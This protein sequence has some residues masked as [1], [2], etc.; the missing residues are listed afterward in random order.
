M[1][2]YLKIYLIFNNKIIYSFLFIITLCFVFINLINASIDKNGLNVRDDF[3][4]FDKITYY[5]STYKLIKVAANEDL[6]N[7]IDDIENP[8]E[9]KNDA[10]K[11]GKKHYVLKGCAA[12]H[13][14]GPNGKG[15][16]G[17]ALNKGVFKH[18]DGS[19]YALAYIITNGIAGTKMGAY[20]ST[21][22]EDEILKLIAYIRAVTKK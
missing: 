22:K 15:S 17:P 19:T 4:W 16:G 8:F 2:K 12:L 14:H 5:V 3:F 7:I 21:L 6:N 13:C 10:I 20:G 11:E 18:S 9:G 1:E